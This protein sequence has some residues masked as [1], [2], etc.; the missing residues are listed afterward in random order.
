MVAVQSWSQ[1]VLIVV[2][3]LG[4]AAHSEQ[5]RQSWALG[6]NIKIVRQKSGEI[7]CESSAGVL[8]VRSRSQLVLI[9]R[10]RGSSAKKGG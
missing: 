3:G 10:L 5:K 2:V 6:E 7:N 1:L 4:R 9:V 8:M